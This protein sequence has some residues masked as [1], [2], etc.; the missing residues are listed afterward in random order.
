M[1]IYFRIWWFQNTELMET[2]LNMLCHNGW[3]LS[4]SI[5]CICLC[6]IY[7]FH[8]TFAKCESKFGVIL[9]IN[10]QKQTIHK[11]NYA[12]CDAPTW[13]PSLWSSYSLHQQWFGSCSSRNNGIPVFSGDSDCYLSFLP[14]SGWWARL[15]KDCK[16]YFPVIGG[17]RCR[18]WSLGYRP[19][20]CWSFSLPR[21]T[22]QTESTSVIRN[23]MWLWF[24]WLVW[25]FLMVCWWSRSDT[26]LVIHDPISQWH[27]NWIERTLR[28]LRSGA[29]F[30]AIEIPHNILKNVH[31]LKCFLLNK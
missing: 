6:I 29:N 5:H 20:H 26:R 17:A 15:A 14:C 27:I 11:W 9:K 1:S 3:S 7:W 8:I 10:K 30:E 18:F 23:V 31:K 12:N 16:R 28:L 25:P 21:R 13:T 4:K 2:T 24:C 19:W 22:T